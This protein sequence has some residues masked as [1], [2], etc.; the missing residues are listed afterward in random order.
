VSISKATSS[1]D[2]SPETARTLSVRPVT[3]L[4]C[5]SPLTVST[6]T[7]GTAESWKETSPLWVIARKFCPETPKR[8]D[9]TRRAGR[10][11]V[12]DDPLDSNIAAGGLRRHIT[13]YLGGTGITALGRQHDTAV[14]QVAHGHIAGRAEERDPRTALRHEHLQ[15]ERDAPHFRGVLYA[16]GR[17]LAAVLDNQLDLVCQ[18]IGGGFVVGPDLQNAC[19]SGLGD[20]GADHLNIAEGVA[21][22]AEPHGRYGRGRF[23][24]RGQLR[25]ALK[26]FR[27]R[28]VEVGADVLDR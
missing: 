22:P 2:A 16:N 25:L 26:L 5:A 15:V 19:R 13:D 28:D 24:R 18:G 6:A 1:A 17:S 12:S 27:D 21:G 10:G 9:V 14:F 4:T 20:I 8:L 3:P 7:T 23:A 11:D